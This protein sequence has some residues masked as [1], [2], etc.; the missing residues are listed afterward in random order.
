MSSEVMDWGLEFVGPDRTRPL[1]NLVTMAWKAQH[2]SDGVIK[3]VEPA[4][5][6]TRYPPSNTK[7][8]HQQ[9]HR[10]SGKHSIEA[11]SQ[12]AWRPVKPLVRTHLRK[13]VNKPQ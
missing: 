5:L 11:Y 9:S 2:H 3:S 12:T 1:R 10:M 8:T 7:P 4:T 13:A 6:Y